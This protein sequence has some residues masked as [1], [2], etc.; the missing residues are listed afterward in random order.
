MHPGLCGFASQGA[1]PLLI[2]RPVVIPPLFKGVGRWSAVDEHVQNQRNEDKR[3]DGEQDDGSDFIAR[4]LGER[5]IHHQ[6]KGNGPNGP[7]EF[8]HDFFSRTDLFTIGL[9]CGLFLVNAPTY[10]VTVLGF[11]NQIST[12]L[13]N[14]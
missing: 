14:G 2:L 11:W 13:P 12:A 5:Y 8:I 3:T 9:C 6:I 7:G 4:Y 1:F 10:T